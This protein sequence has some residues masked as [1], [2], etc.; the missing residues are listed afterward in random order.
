MRSRRLVLC[1]L[2]IGAGSMTGA[3]QAQQI[4]RTTDGTLSWSGTTFSGASMFYA[5]SEAYGADAFPATASTISLF[6][7]ATGFSLNQSGGMS[8]TQTGPISGGIVP[9]SFSNSG[10]LGSYGW[11]DTT[12]A[13]TTGTEPLTLGSQGGLATLNFNDG[14]FDNGSGINYFVFIHL[15]GNWTTQGTSTGDYELNGV[16]AG[17][18]TPTFIFDS[19]TDTTTVSTENPD[20]TGGLVGLNFTL[21]GSAVAGVPEPS[22]W[23]MMLA[24]FAGLGFLGYRRAAKVRPAIA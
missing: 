7:N 6:S 9:I 10:S 2:V 22:T 4:S 1:A 3:A 12:A 18:S 23:A 14:G 24:G 11:T 17:F 5:P 19:G 15:P 16:A 8:V 20:Y 13:D 21:F